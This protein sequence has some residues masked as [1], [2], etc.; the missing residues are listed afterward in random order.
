MSEFNMHA[1]MNTKLIFT[2][3]WQTES[4]PTP[5]P[6]PAQLGRAKPAERNT[7]NLNTSPTGKERTTRNQY[8]SITEIKLQSIASKIQIL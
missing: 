7:H 5:T 8:N 1:G 4:L 3:F 6:K 2:L